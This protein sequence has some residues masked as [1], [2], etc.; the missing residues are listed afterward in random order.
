MIH[1]I[2]F[3]P[4]RDARKLVPDNSKALISIHDDGHDADTLVPKEGWGYYDHIGFD[5]AAYDEELISQYGADFWDY[6]GGCARN[7]HALKILLMF[8]RIE[9]SPYITEII[10]HCDAGRSRSA[11][12]AK[13]YAEKNNLE[14]EGDTTYANSLIYTLL[15][16]PN[17]YEEALEKYVTNAPKGLQTVDKTK[18][19]NLLPFGWVDVLIEKIFGKPQQ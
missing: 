10:V 7:V 18:D 11:A 5:D 8:K 16:N 19:A 3:M 2:S 4:V 9:E 1:H 6:F 17:H 12:V 13:F 14:L 15:K